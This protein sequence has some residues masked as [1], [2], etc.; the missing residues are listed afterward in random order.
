MERIF[1]ESNVETF[2]EMVK[3][4]KGI[5][6]ERVPEVLRLEREWREM[7]GKTPIDT[8][9]EYD[10]CAE[11]NKRH[12]HARVVDCCKDFVNAA[13]EC[14]KKYYTIFSRL[15]KMSAPKEDDGSFGITDLLDEGEAENWIKSYIRDLNDQVRCNN[16][17]SMNESL[18]REA[19]NNIGQRLTDILNSRG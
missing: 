13:V 1:S 16:S 19:V 18:I 6:N 17:E 9:S 11:W 4:L 2:N 5:I 12:A 10:V 3:D 7:V 14:Y 8:T 15:D